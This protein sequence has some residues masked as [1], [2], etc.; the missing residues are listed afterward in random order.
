MTDTVD[1]LPAQ[2]FDYYYRPGQA[3]RPAPQ[4]IASSPDWYQLR[5]NVLSSWRSIEPTPPTTPLTQRLEDHFWQ[6]DEYIDPVVALAFST[7]VESVRDMFERAVEQGI[8]SV[9]NP[10]A[11]LTAFFAHID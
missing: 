5:K 7:S 3:L 4:R 9:D 11:E 2:D 6:G 1:F 10:P 8:E